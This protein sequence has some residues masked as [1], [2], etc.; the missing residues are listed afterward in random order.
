[1][2]ALLIS[3][4]HASIPPQSFGLGII[5]GEPTGISAAYILSPKATIDA[6]LAYSYVRE[7]NW[8]IHSDYLYTGN[9]LWSEQPVDLDTY[10]GAGLRLK[11]EKSTRFGFRVPLGT[12]Y[13]FKLPIQVFGEIVPILDLAPGTDLSIDAAVGARFFF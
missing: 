3:S 8:Q 1:M 4:A 10:M 11:F 12:A 9:R 13:Q 7:G 5:A 2:A 6:A